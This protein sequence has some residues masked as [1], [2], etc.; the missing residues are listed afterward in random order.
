MDLKG[1]ANDVANEKPFAMFEKI[2]SSRIPVIGAMN[3]PALGGGVGLMFA[4][5]IRIVTKD[6]YI[7]FPEVK[8]GIYPALISG[9]IAPQ[10]GPYLTQALMLTGEPFPAEKLLHH[11]VVSSV[12]DTDQLSAAVGSQIQQLLRSPVA[13]HAGVKR[14]VRLVNYCGEYHGEAMQGLAAEFLTMMRTPEAKH[15]LATFAKE[16]KY[17]DWDSYY[18]NMLTEKQKGA[19]ASKL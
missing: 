3:G 8:L 9:Y 12:V 15:G 4:T 6:F 17:P 1:G 16:K 2:W 7:A 10:L 13:A 11:G 14:V 5:D 19:H 18:N